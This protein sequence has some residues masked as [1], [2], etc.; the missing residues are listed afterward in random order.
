M[1]RSGSF[2]FFQPEST[3]LFLISIQNVLWVLEAPMSTHMMFLWRA[4]SSCSPLLAIQLMFI[5]YAL[6]LQGMDTS[7]FKD[8]RAHSR[9]S[10]LKELTRS[11]DLVNSFIPE[12]LEWTLPSIYS[13]KW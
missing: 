11:I 13:I 6:Y 2:F 3:V 4:I 5:D 10:E 12:C 8:G 1:T 7:K 9:N